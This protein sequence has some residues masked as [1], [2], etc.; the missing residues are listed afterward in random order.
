M[1]YYN[2]L[3]KIVLF[4]DHFPERAIFSQKFSTKFRVQGK[5]VN[6]VDL[7][8]KD[9]S[10]DDHKVRLQIWDFGGQERFKYF[11]P[12]YVHGAQGG[13]F[14]Y[15]VTNRRSIDHIDD[16]LSLIRKEIPEDIFPIIAVGIV[17]DEGCERQV[18]SEE[19]IAIVKSRNLNGF[20][21]CNLKTGENI[22]KAFE[23]ITRL[24]LECGGYLDLYRK[25][26]TRLDKLLYQ[27]QNLK[28]KLDKIK[29]K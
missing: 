29:K 4:G 22:E 10:V 19:A 23:A 13:L 24:V 26:Q 12:N 8:S 11:I 16:W 20:V 5:M 1:D 6:G 28:E 15:N 21:E 17:P 9:I 25:E 27:R 18:A 2:Y 3:M 7:A 14:L